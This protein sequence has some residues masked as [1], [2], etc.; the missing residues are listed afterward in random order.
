MNRLLRNSARRRS[1]LFLILVA[2]AVSFNAGNVVANAATTG[3]PTHDR[4]PANAVLMGEIDHP[5]G[6]SDVVG[7]TADDAA[8][9]FEQFRANHPEAIWPHWFIDNQRAWS[10]VGLDGGG[11]E[12]LVATDGTYSPIAND[13]GISFWLRDETTGQLFTPKTDNVTQSLVDGHLPLIVTRW[14]AGPVVVT[15]TVFAASTGANPIEPTAPTAGGNP[16][17]PDRLVLADVSLEA[18]GPPRSWTLYAVVRPF[19]PAG[20][21]SPLN[22]VATTANTISVDGNPILRSQQPATNFGALNESAVDASVLAVRG[23]IPSSTDATSTHG[24]A[25]GMLAY[26]FNLGAGQTVHY[27]FVSP[28]QPVP[29]LPDAL[30]RLDVMGLRE[31]VAAA[32]RERLDRARLTLPDRRVVDA[33]EA[34][35][36][37][38]LM[39]RQ[40]PDLIF[41]GPLSERAFWYRDA[42]YLTMALEKAGQPDVA[43]PIL[44]RMVAAQLPSGRYPPIV[45]P[46]GTARQPMKTEW[47]SQ[48]E[49]IYALLAYAR[50]THDR[51][52]LGEVYPSIRRAAEFQRDQLRQ[53]RAPDLRGTPY[54]GILPAGE[55]AEDLYDASWHHYWDDFWA[56][57]GFQ[58]GAEAA[59]MLGQNADAAWMEREEASLR[60]AVLAGINRTPRADRRVYIPN[61]PEDW[62]SSAMARSATPALW[63]AEVLDPSSA[64]VRDSFEAYYQ[65]WIKPNGGA[66]LHYGNNVW[67]YAGLGLAHAFY[68][69]GMLDHVSE[70]L[71]WTLSHQTAPN[72][73]AWGEEVDP[74]T[75]SFVAGDMPHSWMAAELIL[76]VR[77]MLIRSEGQSLIVGP[78]PA[79]WLPPGGTVAIHDAPT[80][81][82]NAGYT[83]RRSSD[84]R[85]IDVELDNNTPLDDVVLRLPPPLHVMAASID[86]G[87]AT[88][89]SGTE[90]TFPGGTSRARLLVSPAA[91]PES[92]LAQ[93]LG[94]QVMLSG[95]DLSP[96]TVRGGQTVDLS[97]YWKPLRSMSDDYTAFVHVLSPDGE[98]VAQR[99]Q[100]PLDGARPTSRWS[101]GDQVVSQYELVLPAALP[102]GDYPIEVGMYDPRNGR[103]L[104]VSGN[105]GANQNRII[106]AHLHVAE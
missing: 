21:V 85:T 13:L 12:G 106:V 90:V 46:N 72:L 103:R 18:D 69:L 14:A 8:R 81:L 4:R 34:S 97:L 9:F 39:A 91:S 11:V 54:F 99:D 87:P 70:I 98:I 100:P 48:G 1:C 33:Y 58:S 82:G 104:S 25:E 88:P 45:E 59:R 95:F 83:L 2:M 65:Q 78:F 49:G 61:G 68:R 89:T 26:R 37:Y 29:R 79:S 52:F 35:L 96:E 94:N 77:D 19:G 73:N 3:D 53:T 7:I 22:R 42:V 62:Y 51:Q 15:S 31:R 55:S 74:R 20:A 32:W 93:S 47:D 56:I 28:M 60:E 63:P 5:F 41:S 24:L 92:S 6:V 64:L 105:G 71:D 75:S 27:G 84:G 30:D 57:A 16:S 43:L 23:Q 101:P 67:P 40:G 80:T 36:A 17:A 66:Y 44:R 38:L 76:L 86:G 102:P 50:Q 10:V